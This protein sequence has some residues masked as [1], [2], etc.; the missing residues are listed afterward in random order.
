MEENRKDKSTNRDGERGAAL[1][2]ALLISGLLLVIS[3]GLLL[4]ATT[5]TY[6]VTDATAEQQA[7]N[8]AESGIQAAVYVLRDNVTLPD[9]KL[10]VPNPTAGDCPATWDTAPEQCKVNRI[11]YL[12]ALKVSESNAADDTSVNP[13][14]SRWMQYAGERVTMDTQYQYKLDI[15]DPDHTGTI[16]AYS[17]MGKFFDNDSIPPSSGPIYR[18]T[19]GTAP[20][21]TILEYVPQSSIE[22]DTDTPTGNADANFGSF[23]VT[24]TGSGALIPNHNRF[25]IFVRMSKPY[26]G[27]RVI[28]G[29]VS[30]NTAATQ[31]QAPR[32]LFDSRTFT[33]QGS[34]I[35]LDEVGP[36]GSA[37]VVGTT[38][39]EGP[40]PGFPVLLKPVS[41]GTAE[42]VI[43]GRIS[44]PEPIRLLIRSTGYGPRGSVKVLEAIIQKNFFNGITAPATLT[45][46]GPKSGGGLNFVFNPGSSNVTEYSGQDQE[47]TDIIPPIGTTDPDNLSDVHDSVDGLPPHPFNGDVTGVPS[48]VS[49]E[50]GDPSHWLSSPATLDSTVKSLQKVAYEAG[51]YYPSGSQPTT[52]GDNTTG[53]GITFCDGN[54]EFT[55]AGGG[56]MVVTGK[57]T[58]K[59][60]FSFKGMIIVTGTGG[61]NRQ[62]GGNGEIFGNMIVAP[63]LNSRVLP[64]SVVNATDTFMPPQ[65][66]LSGGGN[67]TIA[68]NS[69]ALSDGLLGVSNFVLGVVEK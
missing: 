62:G 50:T 67:S 13:R 42:N 30:P 29:Y 24:I 46:I 63:Y 58:L 61:V 10:I 15:S 65:Y 33:L 43:A 44:S 7:F 52:F 41:A 36:V 3:A 56:I 47:S 1:V 18:K 54:C 48:D 51:R 60:N 38:Y 45:L 32:I 9:D 11:D 53:Q 34:V 66:D 12:K 17:T 28:R 22:V 2:M 57:L 16:V 8:A 14:L 49:L 21:Q 25:E 31:A 26:F 20:N 40:P 23:R 69:T 37:T 39:T 4:E 5:N 35:N 55:G 68:Y 19:Y 59:G 6:N 27:S 64:E